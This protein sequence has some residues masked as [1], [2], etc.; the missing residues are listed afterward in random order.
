MDLSYQPDAQIAPMFVNPTQF[1][2]LKIKH[3]DSVNIN[4]CWSHWTPLIS[5]IFTIFDMDR[6]TLLNF[7][8]CK[9]K[10]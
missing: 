3:L 4:I 6:W 1:V 9:T 5:L 2:A 10:Q 7:I 8:F